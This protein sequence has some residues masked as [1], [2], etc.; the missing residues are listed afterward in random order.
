[1]LILR[2]ENAF[3]MNSAYKWHEGNTH[4]FHMTL[5]FKFD[6]KLTNQYLPASTGR[7]KLRAN[8]ACLTKTW[9]QKNEANFARSITHLTSSILIQ[10]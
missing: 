5:G 4:V 7:N 9:G 3:Q 2:V 6:P 8:F 1:M 10:I